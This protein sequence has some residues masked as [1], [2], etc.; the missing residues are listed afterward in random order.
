MALWR[1][2][3]HQMLSFY[4]LGTITE[5][6]LE[7]TKEVNLWFID[8]T[9]TFDRVR[10]DEIITQLTQLKIGGTRSTNDQKHVP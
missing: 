4:I 2:K 7:K 9:E 10:H 6:P 3:A 5:R 1:G 8:Y